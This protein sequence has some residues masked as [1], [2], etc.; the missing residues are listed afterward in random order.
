MGDLVDRVRVPVEV[1]P[2]REYREIGIRSHGKGVFHKEPILGSDLGD[3]D[4][5]AVLS[6]C[7]TFNIVFAWEQAVAVTTAAEAGMIA[8]HRFPMYRPRDGVLSLRYALYY[9]LSPD[10]K[11]AL[12]VASPGGAGRNRTLS[13]EG[14]R[15]ITIPLPPIEEQERIAAT[16]TTL[17]R[18]IALMRQYFDA[19]KKQ[20]KGLMQKLLTGQVR[21]QIEGEQHVVRTC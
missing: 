18:E 21:V 14:F 7:L 13:Q 5:Y 12:E 1:E 6:D 11:T 3:K 9:L 20:K 2:D 8:S 10:G 4:V 19:L 16:L 17:D 15:K